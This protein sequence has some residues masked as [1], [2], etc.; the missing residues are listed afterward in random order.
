MTLDKHLRSFL[1][2]AVVAVVVV[3]S[4]AILI[5]PL[6]SAIRVE[7]MFTD[8]VDRPLLVMS[9][10]GGDLRLAHAAA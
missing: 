6:F 10:A 5:A 8:P 2:V 1:A 7:P 3:M 4:L 9:P